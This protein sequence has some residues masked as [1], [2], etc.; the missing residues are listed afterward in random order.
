MLLGNASQLANCGNKQMCRAW[1]RYA[2]FFFV[3]IYSGMRPCEVIGLPWRNVN[4]EDNTIEVTQDATEDREIGLPKSASAYRTIHMPAVPA[5]FEYALIRVWKIGTAGQFLPP[6]IF[7]LCSPFNP[8]STRR[9]RNSVNGTIFFRTLASSRAAIYASLSS[10][11]TT[12][13]G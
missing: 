8:A 13:Q 2:P 11:G 6:G 4:F 9:A 1:S 10:N 7:G 12:V 5:F 3:L